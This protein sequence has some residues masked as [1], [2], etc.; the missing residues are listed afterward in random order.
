MVILSLVLSL[1]ARF[2]GR[3]VA[4]DLAG[5]FISKWNPDVER[6]AANWLSSML[7]ACAAVLFWFNYRH[8]QT[9][10]A[11]FASSWR[12]L[13]LIFFGLSCEEIAAFHDLTTT[14]MRDFFH[15]SGLLY[16]AWVIPA[17]F[18][19]LI[20]AGIFV[21]FLRALSPTMRMA[22]IR[23]GLVYV[24]G[25]MGVEALSGFLPSHF[26]NASGFYFMMT[27]VE[28]YMEMAGAVLTVLAIIQ[29]RDEQNNFADQTANLTATR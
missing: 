7:L 14:P 8:Q 26:Q 6:S 18:L 10:K 12:W 3:F 25:A 20:V 16:F 27:Q 23:A 13:S 19:V 21:P 29:F 22:F 17:F 5:E 24:G 4:G 28:E 15:T 2:C 11:R 1:L 9:L